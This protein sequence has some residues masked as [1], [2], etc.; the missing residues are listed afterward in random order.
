MT[1]ILGCSVPDCGGFEADEVF[2]FSEGEDDGLVETP[3]GGGVFSNVV[4]AHT[5]PALM[6]ATL[7][8]TAFQA[9][10]LFM[11]LLLVAYS[12]SPHDLVKSITYSLRMPN[13]F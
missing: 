11:L 13:L 8:V 10:C 3:W 6:K 2:G 9:D 12:H 5:V 4:A 1:V 7:S